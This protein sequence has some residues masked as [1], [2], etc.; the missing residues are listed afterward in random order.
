M[1]K[2]D[3][4]KFV[5]ELFYILLTFYYYNILTFR[6]GKLTKKKNTIENT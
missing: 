4:L 5:I 2:A 3:F 6:N 1:K